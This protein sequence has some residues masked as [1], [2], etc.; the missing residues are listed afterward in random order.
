MCVGVDW[1]CETEPVLRTYKGGQCQPP[2][3]YLARTQYPFDSQPPYLRSLSSVF[4][5]SFDIR[6]GREDILVDPELSRRFG[7]RSR[8]KSLNLALDK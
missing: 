7:T 1:D 5:I 3:F 8:G 2:N 4:D 6:G